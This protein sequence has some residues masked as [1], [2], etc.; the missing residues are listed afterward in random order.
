[1]LHQM[2][3]EMKNPVYA[4]FIDLA[5]PFDHVVRDLMFKTVCQILTPA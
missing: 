4:L 3:D 5:A 1:M 2:T